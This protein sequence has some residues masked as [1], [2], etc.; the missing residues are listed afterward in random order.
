VARHRAA[1]S[2][3]P[4]SGSTVRPGWRAALDAALDPVDRFSEV[5][6]ELIIALSV[7]GSLAWAP[8][9]PS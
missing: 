9:R 6:Y 5:V 1:V 8:A 3:A 7:T 2:F 4:P